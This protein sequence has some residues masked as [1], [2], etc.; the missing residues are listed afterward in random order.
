MQGLEEE[1]DLEIVP[2]LIANSRYQ[3]VEEATFAELRERI[4]DG[5]VAARVSCTSSASPLRPSGRQGIDGLCHGFWRQ[6]RG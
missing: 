2:V 4:V 6:S 1:L 5:I 3:A